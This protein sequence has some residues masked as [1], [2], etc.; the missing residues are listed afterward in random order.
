MTVPELLPASPRRHTPW[1]RLLGRAVLAALG[2]RFEG[3][4]PDL[5]K[6]VIAVAPH[7]S[8]WDFVLG[9]AAVFALD[10][11]AR[12]I[13]KHSLFKG[14]AGALMRRVGGIPVDRRKPGDLVE[15]TVEAF[16]RESQLYLAIAPEGTRFKV[17]R[18]KKGFHR[19]ACA[20]GVPIVPVAFDWRRRVIHLMPVFQPSGSWEA[21]EPLLM[22]LFTREMARRPEWFW[23]S[24]AP[25]K[26]AF[27]P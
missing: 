9:M 8:N 24:Q 26:A 23:T 12:F 3:N 17:E 5:P 16:R 19:I 4:F 25:D 6:C 11:K 1:L 15:R 10:L 7:T 27:K 2:F 22:A 13:G 20:A 18:W 21:D 14:P